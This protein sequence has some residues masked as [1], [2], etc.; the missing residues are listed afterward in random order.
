MN[1]S[2][3]KRKDRMGQH[4]GTGGRP[5]GEPCWHLALEE[6]MENNVWLHGRDGATKEDFS[7]ARSSLP[8]ADICAKEP[9]FLPSSAKE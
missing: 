2:K 3:D 9:D 1:H 7:R 8:P 4:G 5:A 6:G